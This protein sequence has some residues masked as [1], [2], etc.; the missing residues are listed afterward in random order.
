MK[1]P[2]HIRKRHQRHVRV[3]LV[4]HADPDRVAC[5]LE[6]RGGLAHVVPRRRREPDAAP[7]VVPPDDR[8]G[9]VV[10]GE[11]KVLLRLRVVGRLVRDVPDLADLLRDLLDDL[12]VIDDLVFELRP[13]VRGRR[14]CRVRSARPPR[15]A[16]RAGSGVLRMWSTFTC[17]SFFCAPLLD[18]HVLS[19]HMSYAGTKCAHWMIRQIALQP[20]DP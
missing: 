5:R 7:E 18:V 1:E 14:R 10:V 16:A 11:G 20:A 17:M 19:N 4:R 6:L 2:K 13:A 15:P 9:D 8:V 3:E 12:L